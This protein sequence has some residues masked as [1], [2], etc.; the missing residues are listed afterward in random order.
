MLFIE[1][2]P[3]DPKEEKHYISISKIT[4]IKCCEGKILAYIDGDHKHKILAEYETTEE[5]LTSIDKLNTV[6]GFFKV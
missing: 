2:L 5:M 4:N 3:S 6:M 1:V